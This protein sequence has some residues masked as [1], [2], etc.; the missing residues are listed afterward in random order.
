MESSRIQRFMVIVNIAYYLTFASASARAMFTLWGWPD[1]W[2]MTAM[3]GIYLLII[4][5]APALI[6]RNLAYLHGVNA[7][8]TAIVMVLLMGIGPLDYFALLFIPPSIQSVLKFP[9][10][11][12]MIWIGAML[13]LMVAA[14]LLRFPL[15][16]SVGYVIIYP[17]AIFLFTGLC[18][19]AM[20]A[21]RAK[22]RSEALL[23]DLQIANRKL[24][25]YAAQVEE[26]AAANERTR[27]AREL[28][29]S[30]T[31][32][33]FSL[34]LSA[35]SARILLERD[36]SRVAAQLDH[37]QVLA[38]NALAEMRGLIQQLH[39]RPSSGGDLSARLR[40]LASERQ[41][42]D[43]LVVDL[44]L[45]VDLRLPEKT[46][47]ELFRVAQEAVY[48]IVKHAQTD[49]AALSLG[50]SGEKLILCVEDHG[51]GFDPLTVRAAP[52]HLGLT[53]M[54]ERVQALGGSLR[55]ES[56]PGK[57]TRLEVELTLGQEVAHADK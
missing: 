41:A 23:A 5:A 35:Q 16:E 39:P 27:L 43:G 52:G 47:D 1:F 33:I 32:V 25:A 40:Q 36:P 38:Q 14:L 56:Q 34:T 9:R 6:A 8:L 24:Q 53:S 10:R 18:Y 46:A 45:P 31:Q 50:L 11:T 28:H 19:L 2:W 29:D 54:A 30:V 13:L 51:A 4:L 42:E 44:E 55:I 20:E 26:L 21:E 57:G 22:F 3:L 37:I 48:N 7:L 12:A 17:M 15:R 49:R